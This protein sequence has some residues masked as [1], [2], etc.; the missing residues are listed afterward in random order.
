M[1][2]KNLENALAKQRNQYTLLVNS[3]RSDADAAKVELVWKQFNENHNVLL[4][5][6][7]ESH[8]YMQ[9]NVF[10]AAESLYKKFLASRTATKDE[11]ARSLIHD[12][13]DHPGTSTYKE[14]QHLL[15]PTTKADKDE[16][17][18]SMTDECVRLCEIL[19]DELE[20]LNIKAANSLIDGDKVVMERN[21]RKLSNLSSRLEAQVE[22][23]LKRNYF[24][25]KERLEQIQDECMDMQI[26]LELANKNEK[27]HS[28]ITL[29]EMKIEKFGGKEKEWS[30]FSSDYKSLVHNREDVPL[31]TKFIYLK[32]LLYGD[33]RSLVEHL[34]QGSEEN[35]NAVWTL[36]NGHY[37]NKRRLFSDAV[38]AFLD[39]PIL[40]GR[41]KSVVQKYICTIN[42]CAY[43]IKN[44]L[45]IKDEI[46]PILAHIVLRKFDSSVM[47]QY[48]QNTKKTKLIQTLNDVKDFL[49]QLVSSMAMA[50]TS[51]QK[52][53]ASK[54]K[55]ATQQLQQPPKVQ[56]QCKH[57]DKSGH[58]ILNCY[59][60]AKLSPV[61]RQKCAKQHN[62]CLSCLLHEK[63]TQCNKKIICDIC[64]GYHNTLL[65]NGKMENN[66]SKSISNY[67]NNNENETIL[68]TAMV[69][70][71]T[72][73]EEY[74]LV[75]ALI[76]S[77]SQSTLVSKETAQKLRLPR[78]KSHTI[79]HGISTSQVVAKHKLLIS[80]KPRYS[81]NFKVDVEAIVMPKLN[82]SLPN[83]SFEMPSTKLKKYLLADP[84][85]NISSRIDIIIGADMFPKII[86]ANCRKISGCCYKKEHS[87]G[88][89]PETLKGLPVL[90][91]W[92]Q[93]QQLK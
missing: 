82:K 36:L 1:F 80:L 16:D 84:N 24:L 17:V 85:F 64:K 60:F 77:G 93:L 28:K 37:E 18:A 50:T 63:Y 46:G 79:I 89:Y 65:H 92:Q 5:S 19:A 29:P 71:K 27:Q 6:G 66:Q 9:D 26:R 4:K 44:Q 12:A 43:V 55:P 88:L 78:K 75:R 40:D 53:P 25:D 3:I 57:C 21:R 47:Q 41:S 90:K 38:N 7:V 69:E 10:G 13:D 67:T 59:S 68:A 34:L 20:D 54:Y 49:E 74:I 73:D 23:C 22:V 83:K 70:V 11:Q 76:D 39:L 2:S 15:P 58:N 91:S 81:S 87:D 35:Y 30:A 48:E 56:L 45:K 51:S 72:N 32:S 86:E 62:L 42:E 8:E 61:E 31:A 33:A 52:Y 14:E